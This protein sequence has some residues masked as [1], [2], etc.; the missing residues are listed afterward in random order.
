VTFQDSEFL[1]LQGIEIV[2]GSLAE[3]ATT[4]AAHLWIFIHN[5]PVASYQLSGEYGEP[6]MTSCIEVIKNYYICKTNHSM[7][8]EFICGDREPSVDCSFPG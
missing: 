2:G 6:S 5:F 3:I 8:P 1:Y 4:Y 7:R